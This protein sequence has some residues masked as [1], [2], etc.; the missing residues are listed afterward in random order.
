MDHHIDEYLT[1][2]FAN[3]TVVVTP[4]ASSPVL[5]NLQR[6]LAG[7]SAASEGPRRSAKTLKPIV[8]RLIAQMEA[9]PAC[10]CEACERCGAAEAMA[11]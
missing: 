6:L 11:A 10:E 1:M 8:D 3:C 4:T 9:A 7:A 2:I 5:I